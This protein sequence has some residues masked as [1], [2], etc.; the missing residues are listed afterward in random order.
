[1]TEK[2]EV[3]AGVAVIGLWI[4]GF[5]LWASILSVAN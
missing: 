5:F 2:R 3:V 4:A 1:M